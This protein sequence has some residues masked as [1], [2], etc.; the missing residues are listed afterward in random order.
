MVPHSVNVSAGGTDVDISTLSCSR[1]GSI[2]TDGGA[3]TIGC[4][5][6]TMRVISG[7]PALLQDTAP[8][9]LTHDGMHA[10]RCWAATLGMS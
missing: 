8:Q 2:L 4:L 3:V 5:D 7:D 6:G 10:W 9:P 1:D